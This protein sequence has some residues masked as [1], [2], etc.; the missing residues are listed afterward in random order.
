M[1]QISM[2]EFANGYIGQREAHTATAAAAREHAHVCK[3]RALS[4]T[5]MLTELNCT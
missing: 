3:S 1:R 4:L 2:N 5:H